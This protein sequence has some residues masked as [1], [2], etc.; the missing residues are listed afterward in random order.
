MLLILRFLFSTGGAE[1]QCMD[2]ADT[3]DSGSLDLSDAVTLLMFL[4]SPSVEDLP[5]P[6]PTTCGPDP[7]EDG[8]ECDF[9][10]GCR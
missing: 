6:G 9:V 1:L 8:L 7:T 5:A 4:F 10:V 2:A 3:N